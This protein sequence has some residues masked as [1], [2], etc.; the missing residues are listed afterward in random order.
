[1]RTWLK[2]LM[3]WLLV[4]SLGANLYLGYG[5]WERDRHANWI[6]WGNTTRAFAKYAHWGT[7]DVEGPDYSNSRGLT[8]ANETLESIR[9]LPHYSDRVDDADLRTIEMFLRYADASLGLATREQ[10]K[11]GAASEES[12]RRL[13]RVREGLRLIVEVSSRINELQ[14]DA[15]I[16]RD[17]EWR[18]MW[19]EMAQQLNQ[20]EFLPLPK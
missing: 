11:T 19:H 15:Y 10:L 3:P 18:K 17:G 6:L 7:L 2:Q 20:I 12:R 13:D 1:M 9:W 4:L 8:L 5:I 14:K 16:W